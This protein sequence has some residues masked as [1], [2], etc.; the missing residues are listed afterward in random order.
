VTTPAAPQPPPQGQPPP[1][2]LDDPALAAA[3]AAVLAA[4]ITG[5]ALLTAAVGRLAA[6]FTLTAV[7]VTALTVI[8]A[9]VTSGPHPVSGVTG[10][11][12]AQTSRMN[13]ARRVQFVVAASKRVIAAVRDARA[14]GEPGTGAVRDQLEQERRFYE[15]HRL[16]MANRAAAAARTDSAAAVHGPIL[17]WLSKNDDRTS[18]ECRAASGWNYYASSMPDIGFPG[19]AH[20]SCRCQPVAPWPGG[21]VLPGS[22]PGYARA[23]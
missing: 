21:R 13:L 9:L 14:K 10:A 16:A 20:P 5:P 1:S 18:P 19:A 2:G 23:A 7:A 17:G 6:R 11:A 3:V 4:G 22:H 8:L 12:S 15:Q